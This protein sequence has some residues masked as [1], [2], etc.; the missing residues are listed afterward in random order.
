M[1]VFLLKSLKLDVG[2]SV[3]WK[4]SECFMMIVANDN[5]EGTRSSILTAQAGTSHF[6]SEP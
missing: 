6:D 1:C 2:F 4:E 5:E 3:D